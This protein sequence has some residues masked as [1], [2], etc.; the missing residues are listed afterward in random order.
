MIKAI[1]KSMAIPLKKNRR[2]RKH[3]NWIG[4]WANLDSMGFKMP[5]FTNKY[6]YQYK[7]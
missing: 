5:D 3:C 2:K 1:P 7:R 6:S 4:H